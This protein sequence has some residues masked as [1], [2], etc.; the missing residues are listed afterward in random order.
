MY[1]PISQVLED[2]PDVNGVYYYSQFSAWWLAGV[3]EMIKSRDMML[4]L[5]NALQ[6]DGQPI[7]ARVR[8]GYDDVSLT[9]RLQ[10]NYVGDA[11]D[12]PYCHGLGWLR[13][14]RLNISLTDD[15]NTW[16]ALSA[17]ECKRLEQQQ[18]FTRHELTFEY[19]KYNRV[20]SARDFR[21]HVYGKC[22]MGAV[23]ME[24]AWCH[25]GIV[26]LLEDN[27]V[28]QGGECK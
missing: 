18:A 11:Y 4:A 23:A 6:Q 24:I 15:Y 16:E 22:L 8:L 27:Y 14:Q 12:I 13:G 1:R 5:A 19:H 25:F 26:C 7:G 2:N 17:S 9:T 28:G 10:P 21:A 20:F 3:P